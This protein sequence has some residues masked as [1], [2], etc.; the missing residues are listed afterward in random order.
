MKFFTKHADSHWI[1]VPDFMTNLE[2]STKPAPWFRREFVVARETAGAK[3]AIS[4]LGYYEVYINGKRVGDHVLDPIVS[5]YDRHVLYVVHDVGKLLKKGR[6]TIGVVLG[7]GWY[8]AHSR[9]MWKLEYAPWRDA[10]KMR[11]EMRISSGKL[12]V[13]SDTEWKCTQEGPILFDGLRS[14]ETYDAGREFDGWAKNNFDDSLW[15]K[16]AVTRSPGGLLTEQTGTP[17]RIVETI[18]LSS[19]NN[20]NVYDL[21]ANIAGHVRITVRGKAGAKVTIRYAERLT[22]DGDLSTKHQEFDVLLGERWQTDEYILRGDKLKE[23]WEPRFTYHGFQYVKITIEGEAE[24][25]NLEAR[26]VNSDFKSVGSFTSGNETINALQKI[27]RCSYLANFVGIPTDCPHREKNGWT[28]DAQLASETGLCNFD[29]AAGYRQWL[30]TMR[31]CQRPDGNLPGIVPTGGWGFNWGNGPAWDC[32]LFVIP[33]NVYLYTGD[34]T[35]IRE[36]YD[37]MKRYLNYAESAA[38]NGITQMG[39]GDWCSDPAKLVDPRLTN[40]AIRYYMMNIA[41]DIADVLKKNGEAKTIRNQAKAVQK[42]FHKEFYRGNGIYADDGLTAMGAALYFG[43]CPNERVRKATLKHLAERVEECNAKAEFGIIGAKAVP[44]V[45]AEN[46]YAELASRFFTQEEFPGWAYWVVTE[47]ATSLHEN[48]MDCSSRNHIMFGDLSAWCFR[49]PGGF[50]FDAAKPGYKKLTIQPAIIPGWKSFKAE[51][52][53]YIT[54]WECKADGKSVDVNITVPAK[55]SATVIL[56]D[57]QK[58]LWAHGKYKYQCVI[59]N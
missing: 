34:T 8:N 47:H 44:R 4:G 15:I 43:L 10:P 49:Y 24:L 33:W 1:S 29:A 40:T 13:S 22:D 26:R 55:C 21:A 38:L 32:A 57:G 11:L 41:A 35:L 25:I 16:A 19:P 20:F 9:G 50:R 27:T 18:P 46:G 39:L 17:I 59:E 58:K 28:G 45:L 6:N 42:A 56:P 2:T 3:L 31:D 36:N 5:V 37:A 14:G 51:H 52:R 7:T 54:E 53:G 12:L 48:W 30:A 23:V